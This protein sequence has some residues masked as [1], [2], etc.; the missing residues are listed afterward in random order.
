MREACID[1]L[2]SNEIL[3][4]FAFSLR[5]TVGIR[6]LSERFEILGDSLQRVIQQRSQA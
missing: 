3:N 2:A 5:S 4:W 6:S 1:C